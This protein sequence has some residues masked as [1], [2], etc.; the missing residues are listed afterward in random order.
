MRLLVGDPVGRDWL[1]N[2][3]YVLLE[4]EEYEY[5]FTLHNVNVIGVKQ[6]FALY[7]GHPVPAAVGVSSAARITMLLYMPIVGQLSYRSQITVLKHELLHII[8][9]HLSAYGRRLIDDYGGTVAN[10]AKDIYVNQRISDEELECLRNDGLPPQTVEYYGFPRDLSSEEYCQL[11]QSGQGKSPMP[12]A[13]ETELVEQGDGEGGQSDAGGDAE[14]AA[15]EDAKGGG[16]GASNGS[17]EE[18]AEGDPS[19][20]FAGQG[21]YRPSEVFDLSKDEGAAADQA[22]REVLRSVTET[23]EARGKEWRANR[24]FGGADHAAFVEASKRQ[25]RTPWHYFLRAL[26]SRTRAE[27]V[28]PTRSR[29]SR[30]NPHHM[31]RVRRYGLDA[32]FMIDTSGSMGAEQ[33]QLVDA[34]L[35][36][37]HT[38]GAHIKVVHC[39]A[40]VAKIEDYSP[41]SPMERFHG[42]GGT[43]F[44]PALLA[45]RDLYPVPGMFVGFTDGY[46]GIEEYVATIIEERGSE[47]YNEFVARSPS[48]TPDGVEA[49]WMLPEGCMTPE[50]FQAGV[51]PWGQVI[52]VPADQPVQ[53]HE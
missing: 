12:E 13:G 5:A 33:L 34:E 15:D 14:S 42:R 44:S 1:T 40:A 31:G 46:G 9:G 53:E 28:V 38:R 7:N 19:G 11:L 39:D 10:I 24:G 47:W 32:A 25:S 36:G 50:E 43:D 6:P 16:N 52:V 37:M 35:R 8:E 23:L 27:R 20:S 51:C 48:V 3:I 22:T 29:L 26:E 30:R 41:F 45:L 18:A 17:A 2:L 49:L 21:E 4:G